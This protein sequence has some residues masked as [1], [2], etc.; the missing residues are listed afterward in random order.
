LKSYGQIAYETYCEYC[1][2]K[3][4]YDGGLGWHEVQN[5]LREAWEAAANKVLETKKNLDDSE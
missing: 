2:W 5:G 4:F 1:K 3:S